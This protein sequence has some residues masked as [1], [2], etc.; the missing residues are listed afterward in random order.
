[1]GCTAVRLSMLSD[2]P[3]N[4]RCQI[5][6]SSDP[7][8]GFSSPAAGTE[9]PLAMLATCHE[10]GA[11]QCA[12]LK[13][14][15]PHLA[16]RGADEEA[17]TAAAGVLRYFDKA[18][19]DHYADEELDLF[20]ALLESMAAS[21]AVCL[22]AMIE[23]LIAEH[24]RLEHAWQLVRDELAGV[25][26]GASAQ[27]SATG[28]EALVSLYERHMA[29]EDDELMPMA[30]R[31]LG[32]PELARIGVAMRARRGIDGPKRPAGSPAPQRS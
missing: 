21:D 19:R 4:D 9:A 29:R 23:G 26:A 10:R 20:P 1:M 16:A 31:M 18:A 8:P 30:T 2:P 32:E 22:R 7:I 17:R 27:L 13:S 15:Q 24:R 25:A 11:R 6:S 3:S 12:T 14:L 5:M 28:V